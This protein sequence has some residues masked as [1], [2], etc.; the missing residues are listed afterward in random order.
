VKCDLSDLIERYE[1]LIAHPSEAKRI[2]ENGLRF[3]R[4]ILHPK[5]LETYF[6]AVLDKCSELYAV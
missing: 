5:A 4:E 2:A 6:L 1:W 3:A